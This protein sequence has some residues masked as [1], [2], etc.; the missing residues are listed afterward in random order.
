MRGAMRL[1]GLEF[2]Q[3]VDGVR[4]ADLL[5][6]FFAKPWKSLLEQREYIFSRCFRVVSPV[7]HAVLLKKFKNLELGQPKCTLVLKRT[8]AHLSRACL[9]READGTVESHPKRLSC[10]AGSVPNGECRGEGFFR[11]MTF[12]VGSTSCRPACESAGP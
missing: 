9:Q 2:A 8:Q 1:F 6:A 10:A 11:F 4:A 5:V 7:F 3:F 12:R